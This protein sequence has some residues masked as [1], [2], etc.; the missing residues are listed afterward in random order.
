MSVFGYSRVDAEKRFG[1]FSQIGGLKPYMLTDGRANGLRAVDFRTTR[2]FEFTVLLDRAMDISE[3][4]YK[5]M[6]IA[7]RSLSGDVGPA[8]YDPRGI[9]WLRTFFGGL[10]ATCGLQQA[11]AMN[12]D[13]GEELGLH[14]RVGAT[15]A[16][17]VSY[18]QEWSGDRPILQ[19]GGLMREASL[20]GP[21]L[22]MR[23]TITAFGDGASLAVRDS[24]VNA[25][26]RRTPCML[27][28][29]VNLGF[30]LIDDGAELIL[31]TTK[32]EPSNAIAE[33][34]KETWNLMHAP[35]HGYVEKVYW[36]TLKPCKEGYAN[37]AVI[38]RKL[39]G[40]LGVRLRYRTD[41]L[42][43]F[44]EWKMLG[45]REYVLGVEPGNCLPTGRAK[46]RAAGRLVEL[47]VGQQL[48]AGFEIEVVEGKEAIEKLVKEASR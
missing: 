34:G 33:D 38:N 35:I 16:E 13:Q 46:E 19:V 31:P 22:E 18:S 29:H 43:C 15:C 36:H 23:R 11:G 37:I 2:G 45:E 32:V 20:F 27:L 48:T 39:G 47:E 41:E 3:A 14:G 8:Y 17:M 10:L 26:A 30:P 9:E 44:T 21:G 28:Y 24:I 7:W 12:T 25:G 4:R 5:G 6:S 40:G 42:P 1:H